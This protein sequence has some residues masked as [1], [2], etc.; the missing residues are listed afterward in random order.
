MNEY[1]ATIETEHDNGD[2]ARGF[3]EYNALSSSEAQA[4]AFDDLAENQR[5]ISVWQRVL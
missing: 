4:Y 2:I 1:I 3:V 5:V